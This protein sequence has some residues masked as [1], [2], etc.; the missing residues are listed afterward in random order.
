[1]VLRF[2]ALAVSNSGFKAPNAVK[3]YL[4]QSI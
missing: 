2:M 3:Q 4:Q 1:L